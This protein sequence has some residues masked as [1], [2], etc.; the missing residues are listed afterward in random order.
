V[1]RAEAE[2]LLAAAEARAEAATP[3]PWTLHANELLRQQGEVLCRGG[4]F[5]RWAGQPDQGELEP[6]EERVLLRLNMNFEPRGDAAFIAHARTDVPA[7][8]RLARE[9]M[10]DIALQ[11]DALLRWREM[12]GCDT[13]VAARE[14]MARAD[15]AE[16]RADEEDRA[17]EKTIAQRDHF[18]GEIGRLA[19]RIGCEQEWSNMHAHACCIDDAIDALEIRA[20]NAEERAEAAETLGRGALAGLQMTEQERDG[21]RTRAEAAE[22]LLGP[23]QEAARAWLQWDAVSHGDDCAHRHCEG[24][25][26]DDPE[27]C[28]EPNEACTCSRAAEDR[29]RDA[30]RAALA[31]VADPGED[32][33]GAGS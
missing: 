8:V 13:P 33:G 1:T 2:A 12:T 11:A 25:C 6:H 16:R 19:E 24:E 31:T 28:E 20:A 4:R 17:H 26:E 27:A 9:H 15:A 30:L 21:W 18:E 3:G 14:Q 29:L 7:L 10:A 5:V 23:V 32:A 22:A